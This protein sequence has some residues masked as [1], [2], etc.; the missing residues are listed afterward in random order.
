M[1]IAMRE[2]RVRKLDKRM[3]EIDRIINATPGTDIIR[4]RKE[5]IERAKK[6]PAQDAI[7]LI[8]Q[9][10]QKESD[11]FKLAEEQS[12]PSL[13]EKKLKIYF[14][15]KKLKAEIFFMKRRHENV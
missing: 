7:R 11:L 5:T 3:A 6:M 10:R 8:E 15:I 13:I 9:A 1:E 14:E 12:Y 4:L 2:R